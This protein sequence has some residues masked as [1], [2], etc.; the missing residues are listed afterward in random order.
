MR[1]LSVASGALHSTMDVY[2]YMLDAMRDDEETN[3]VPFALHNILAY[4][5]VAVRGVLGQLSDEDEYKIIMSRA[6]RELIADININ[7][8]DFL[9]VTSGF[10]IP[11]D[12]WKNIRMLRENLKYP[13]YTAM[14]F[15]ES[16]YLD[17]LQSTLYPFSD[18]IFVNDKWSVVKFDPDNTRHVY[19][20]PHSYNPK[21]HYPDAN[22][23][24]NFR[25]D[26]MFCG[27]CFA[28]RLETINS[29]DW[30]NIDFKLIGRWKHYLNEQQMNNLGSKLVDVEILHNEDLADY[31]RGAK[32]AL[33]IHRT[34]EDLDIDGK[35]LNNYTDAYSIGPRIFESAACGALVLSDYRAEIID[36]FGD[37]SEVFHNAE[38]LQYKVAYWTHP[39]NEERRRNKVAAASERIKNCTFVDR[40]QTIIKPVFDNIL[41]MEKQNE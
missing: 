21:I 30:S 25:S 20:L 10:A 24:S 28:E 22:M 26:V 39:D 36:V 6:V 17:P 11:N 32:I 13:Y 9:F 18:V 1:V 23:D 38:E 33:N 27:T 31:Y 41:E 29:V 40:Y 34:R 19:Y 16:P 5:K 35:P 2:Q 12:G 14:Y 3:V 15:T 4:H 37:T 8:P 7:A